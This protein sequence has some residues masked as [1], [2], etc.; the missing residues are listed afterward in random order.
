MSCRIE[1]L[2][3]AVAADHGFGRRGISPFDGDRPANW[4]TKF[5][6]AILVLRH[7]AT[8]AATRGRDRANL[9]E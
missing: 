4:L 2:E 8:L 3:R 1:R 5:V 7:D 6:L 9:W